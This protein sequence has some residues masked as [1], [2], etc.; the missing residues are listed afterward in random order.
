MKQFF[1]VDSNENG[2]ITLRDYNDK[3][4]TVK[5]GSVPETYSYKGFKRGGNE[6]CYASA[7]DRGYI[8]NIEH[9]LKL[10]SVSEISANDVVII[11][12]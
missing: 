11:S 8:P 5:V 9:I 4:I 2:E 12:D 3:V 7:S 10:K 1:N 6:P